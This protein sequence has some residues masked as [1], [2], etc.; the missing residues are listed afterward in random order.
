MMQCVKRID[1]GAWDARLRKFFS[2]FLVLLGSIFPDSVPNSMGTDEQGRFF[3]TG[4][5][6]PLINENEGGGVVAGFL[7]RG[8]PFINSLHPDFMVFTGD[9]VL[10]G[11]QGDHRFPVETITRQY[12]FFKQ[13]VLGKINAQ[14]YCVAGNHD[15]GH[16]PH[17]PSVELFETLL[18]PLQFS[19]AY[20]GS[21]FLLLSPYQPFPH[22]PVSKDIPPLRTI[23]ESYDT[24]A[25][26][27]FLE[28][29]RSELGERYKHIFIFIS[30][31][32]VSDVPLGYYWSHFVI[33]LLSSLPQDVYVFSTD[34]FT[35][36][37]ENRDVHNV[38]RCNN[39]R[40]YPFAVFPRGGYIVSFD[41]NTVNITMVKGTGFVPVKLQEIAYRP[42][43]RSSMALRYLIRK[44]GYPLRGTYRYCIYLIKQAFGKLHSIFS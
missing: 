19:F 3:V 7:E 41:L 17:A 39:V 35:R 10:G 22:V 23:W 27:A 13:E 21:L 36:D 16:M 8:V 37:R 18:N 28:Y 5:I 4:H 12:A 9:E 6:R 2:L 40:F 30:A 25:S 11:M 44:I 42:A 1:A 43:S 24:P 26:R 38:M 14:A 15:T 20:K 31:S 33:P 34:Q 32:P 29:L